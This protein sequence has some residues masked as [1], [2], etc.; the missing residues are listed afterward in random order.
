M[1]DTVG[2][3]PDVL[4]YSGRDRVVVLDGNMKV[5]SL[6]CTSIRCSICD[7]HPLL[8]ERKCHI[9][10]TTPAFMLITNTSSVHFTSDNMNCRVSWQYRL[11]NHETRTKCAH[12]CG[13]S[14][15]GSSGRVEYADV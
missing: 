3:T 6:S 14:F 5:D 10:P 2:G 11:A 15:P 9:R 4:R 13:G 12:V 7:L 1:G 8:S